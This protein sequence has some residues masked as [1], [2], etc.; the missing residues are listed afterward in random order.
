M[1]L[2]W[3][4]FVHMPFPG[5][6]VNSSLGI[7]MVISIV[8]SHYTFLVLMITLSALQLM[9]ARLPA[10][11]SSLGFSILPKDTM[12][13]GTGETGI[14]PQRLVDGTLY[15]LSHSHLGPAMPLWVWGQDAWTTLFVFFQCI[16]RLKSQHCSCSCSSINKWLLRGWQNM[17]CITLEKCD[18]NLIQEINFSSDDYIFKYDIIQIVH[19]Q[20]DIKCY[21]SPDLVSYF[22]TEAEGACTQYWPRYFVWILL[23]RVPKNRAGKGVKYS[24]CNFNL[25]LMTLLKCT[26]TSGLWEWCTVALAAEY[27]VTS[28]SSAH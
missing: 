16:L 4:L 12:A 28:S 7:D 25:D 24:S 20:R 10:V 14:E 13:H 21:L 1:S 11:R 8:L 17:T 15:L 3:L 26:V 6:I 18:K 19:S 2:S 5:D 9:F 27:D 23:M 22:Q